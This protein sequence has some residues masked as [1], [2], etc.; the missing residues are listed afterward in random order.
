M[1]EETPDEGQPCPSC[2]MPMQEL[3]VCRH[4]CASS[5][6]ASRTKEGT[7][8]A[9]GLG[10]L[11]IGVA[12]LIIA[13]LT[14]TAIAPI[15]DLGAE[16]AFQHFRIKGEVTRTF[17]LRTPYPESDVYSFWVADDSFE[18]PRARGLKVKV[19]GTLYHELAAQERVPKKG[20]MVDVEGTL[21]AGDYF[22]LLSVNAAAMVRILPEDGD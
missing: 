2:G 19:A 14:E 21:Y 11:A 15:D 17:M 8:K 12:L 16:S 1:K 7:L 20:D 3:V 13:A 10:V 4:C 5:A 22:R 9:W 18:D 6:P